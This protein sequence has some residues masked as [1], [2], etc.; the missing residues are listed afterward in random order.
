MRQDI[1]KKDAQKTEPQNQKPEPQ[2]RKSGGA[3]PLWGVLGD[4]RVRVMEYEGQPWYAAEDVLC[5]LAESAHPAELWSDL[6]HRE[7]GLSRIAE[8][9]EMPDGSG[10][11]TDA[12]N[13]EGVLRMVE[14]IP[15]AA[16]EKLKKWMARAA[17]ER[18]EE[19]ED[20]ELAWVRLQKEYGHRGYSHRWV[21][22]RLRGMAARQELVSEWARRGAKESEEYRQLTNVLIETAFGMDVNRYRESKDLRRNSQNLRD[23]M[24]DLELTL[25]MLGETA[26]VEL[27]RDHNAQ[28][29]EQLQADVKSAGE[30]AR[31]ARVE[32]ERRAG[33][34]I[35]A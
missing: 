33:R 29:F 1:G 16:A 3:M 26:A 25:T 20:P 35:A 9:L 5:V 23:H 13:L 19:L 21:Q 32:I 31:M 8:R 11:V 28:G 6:K 4:P 2:K 27:H 14:S 15:S 22:K 30:V 10:E 24:T 34:S 18:V 7:P 17:R 12:V